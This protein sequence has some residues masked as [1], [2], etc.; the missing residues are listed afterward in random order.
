MSWEDED[1]RTLED[2]GRE[3]SKLEAELEEAD[4]LTEEQINEEVVDDQC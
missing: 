2:I 1:E 4:L 3:D